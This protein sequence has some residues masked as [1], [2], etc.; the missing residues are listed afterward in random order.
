MTMQEFIKML[1][2]A[3]FQVLI[4]KE[5]KTYCVFGKDNKI[6]Y[7]QI[8]GSGLFEFSTVHKPNSKTG[9]GYRIHS[10]ITTPTTKHAEDAFAFVPHWANRKDM[11]TIVK[12]KS[13]DDY[14]NGLFGNQYNPA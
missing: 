10:D 11:E 12:Y 13:L 2:K 1:K 9:T 14:K 7:C 4:P 5:S 3:G 6:G 8:G